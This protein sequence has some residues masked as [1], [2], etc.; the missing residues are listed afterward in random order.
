MLMPGTST[1]VILLSALSFL[2][3]GICFGTESM[4]D[5]FT[6]T[7]Q[8]PESQPANWLQ[9]VINGEEQPVGKPCE[10]Y[11]KSLNVTVKKAN[12]D[13]ELSN[14]AKLHPEFKSGYMRCDDNLFW[15]IQFF[16]RDRN[17]EKTKK[18]T[19][20]LIKSLHMQDHDWK[21]VATSED[22]EGIGWRSVHAEAYQHNGQVMTFSVE[23]ASRTDPIFAIQLIYPDDRLGLWSESL[24]LARFIQSAEFP[25]DLPCE[26]YLKDFSMPTN[27]DEW[28]DPK[29][30][31]DRD[32]LQCNN[33]S[34]TSLTIHSGIFGGN[35]KSYRQALS[36][37]A[38]DV[39]KRTRLIENGWQPTPTNPANP[40]D[41]NNLTINSRTFRRGNKTITIAEKFYNARKDG[42]WIQI[43]IN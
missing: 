24:W 40:T 28:P 27:P 10:E 23:H 42:L 7:A 30:S 2:Q 13:F 14:T 20:D 37:F 9:R 26:S 8:K 35:T 19:A 25:T 4:Q 5:V 6:K 29:W 33:K 18:A 36:E 1:L 31:A 43:F 16:S 41:A 15:F 34:V 21:L 3:I 12:G 32:T 11:L 38:D 17:L 22:G 39:I